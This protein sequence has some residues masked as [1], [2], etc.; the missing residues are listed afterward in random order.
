MMLGRKRTRLPL[1]RAV[2]CT[3]LLCP[4][5]GWAEEQAHHLDQRLREVLR[6]AEFTGRVESTLEQRLGRPLNRPL[7]DLGRLLWFDVVGGIHNDNTCG[8]CHSPTHG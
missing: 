4:I 1:V 5:P 3:L 8:G 7:V 2:F 6:A